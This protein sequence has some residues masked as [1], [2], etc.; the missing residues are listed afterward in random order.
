MEIGPIYWF[1]NWVHAWGHFRLQR[2]SSQNLQLRKLSPTWIYFTYR[3]LNEIYFADSELKR[4]LYAEWWPSS[5]GAL[6]YILESLGCSR[7]NQRD[8]QRSRVEDQD[9]HTIALR[10][11]KLGPENIGSTLLLTIHIVTVGYLTSWSQFPR[12]LRRAYNTNFSWSSWRSWSACSRKCFAQRLA[13]GQPWRQ[14]EF[15]VTLYLLLAV[16]KYL[17]LLVCM[18]Q[19]GIKS[20]QMLGC[21]ILQIYIPAVA[22]LTRKYIAQ[23]SNCGTCWKSRTGK[24]P[25]IRERSLMANVFA[26][27]QLVYALGI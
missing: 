17:L 12:C 11:C 16:T 5:H 24:P 15:S 10:S 23:Y 3:I 2:Y 25:S 20:T 6:T 27:L 14:V 19:A 4:G 1:S 9:N 21:R 7:L 22:V 13:P 26:A 8:T 18:V